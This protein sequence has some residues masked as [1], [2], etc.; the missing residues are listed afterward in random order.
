MPNR[1]EADFLANTITDKKS[2]SSQSYDS[3]RMT[4]LASVL[5]NAPTEH[6]IRC[7]SCMWAGPTS[8]SECLSCGET[9]I[10]RLD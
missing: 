2:G 9:K 6:L 3:P 10:R 7:T 5:F 1:F 8:E 4:L